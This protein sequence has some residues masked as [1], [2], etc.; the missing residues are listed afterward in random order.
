MNQ[1]KECLNKSANIEN[2]KKMER[3][4]RLYDIECK[5]EENNCI[6]YI[7]YSSK[8]AKQKAIIYVKSY[9]MCDCEYIDF[10]VKWRKKFDKDLTNVKVGIIDEDRLVEALELGIYGYVQCECRFCDEW[11]TCSEIKDG[12]I[13]CDDCLDKFSSS[14]SSSENN[15]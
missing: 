15:S 5:C 8:E 7:G 1:L 3:Q 9:F 2:T 12:K 4:K 6:S 14:M 10:K 13:I 11:M